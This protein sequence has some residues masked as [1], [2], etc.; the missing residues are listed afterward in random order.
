MSYDPD[1][2][3]GDDT[4]QMTHPDMKAATAY[5][6]AVAGVNPITDGND[7]VAMA[8]QQAGEDTR[9]MIKGLEDALAL[10]RAA[11]AR[12]PDL[13]IRAE[14]DRLAGLL[15]K[16]DIGEFSAGFEALMSRVKPF[17]VQS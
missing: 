14:L 7:P 4:V 9:A 5:A 8:A 1:S 12:Y 2:Q 11:D 15:L 13:G 6:L 3:I 17:L 16:E 10:L